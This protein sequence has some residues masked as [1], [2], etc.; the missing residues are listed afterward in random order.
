MLSRE[1]SIKISCNVQTHYLH[2]FGLNRI[3][4][5][6][7]SKIK[8]KISQMQACRHRSNGIVHNMVN[9]RIFSSVKYH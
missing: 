7:A 3:Q 8:T 4:L 9:L 6:I 1:H 2:F 5:A